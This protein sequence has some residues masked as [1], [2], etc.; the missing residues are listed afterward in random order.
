MPVQE[1]APMSKLRSAVL[2]AAA[3]LAASGGVAVMAPAGTAAAHGDACT[4]APDS[5]PV[6]NFHNACHAHD[7]CYANKPYGNSQWGRLQCDNA[8]MN[9]M[10]A[11]CRS[12][13]G[14]W[15]PAR[16]ACYDVANLYFGAVVAAGWYYWD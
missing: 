13:Y 1:G 9:D 12:R 15:N 8:F 16:Y 11:S 4:N 10:R 14:S 7:N 3:T 2:A 5:G 6:W